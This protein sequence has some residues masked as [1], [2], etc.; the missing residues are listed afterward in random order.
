MGCFPEARSGIDDKKPK[1]LYETFMNFARLDEIAIME[2]MLSDKQCG[3]RIEDYFYK[4]I[5]EG[6]SDL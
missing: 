4:V 5:K 1:C 3:K 2:T 6:I